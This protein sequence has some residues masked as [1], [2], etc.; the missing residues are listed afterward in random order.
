M[1]PTSAQMMAASQFGSG[2][3]QAGGQIYANYQNQQMAKEQ[4][5]FQER[6]SSTAHQRE[7]KDLVAAGLNPI[8]SATGGHGASTPAGAMAQM[9]N[10]G[11]GLGKGLQEA[12]RS[13]LLDLP[14]LQNESRLAESA[15]AKQEAETQNTRIDSWL[16]SQALDRGGLVAEKLEKDI[17]QTEQATRTSA[18]Q[19]IA[20]TQQGR[21]TEQ[22]ANLLQSLVPLVENGG[23]ALQDLMNWLK[24]KGPE[25]PSIKTAIGDKAWEMVELARKVGPYADPNAAAKWLLQTA[26]KHLPALMGSLDRFSQGMRPSGDQLQQAID[27]RGP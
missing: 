25:A 23:N 16:K 13:T 6:M 19:E 1:E 3:L 4:M 8:L 10:I 20:T 12:A 26:F 2:V 17:I 9:G 24:Q 7:V 15:T 22:E 14:R 21:R 5:A 18:A 11:E 27:A